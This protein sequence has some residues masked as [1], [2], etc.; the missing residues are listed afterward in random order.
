MQYLD[1]DGALEG[2][3]L[4]FTAEGAIDFQTPRGKIP[5][6]V[7]KRAKKAGLPVIV[8]AGMIGKDAEINYEYGIEAMFSLLKAPSTLDETIENAPQRL[9]TCA[10]NAMRSVV[11]GM[12]ITSMQ[13]P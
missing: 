4:V 13:N 10:E 8:I 6:E 3:D 12:S 9:T 7:A 5:A 1:L 11:V 2:A